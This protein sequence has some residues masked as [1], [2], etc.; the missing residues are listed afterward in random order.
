[1]QAQDKVRRDRQ[2]KEV[3]IHGFFTLEDGTKSNQ[4]V[5]PEPRAKLEI[6]TTQ[7]NPISSTATVQTTIGAKP[8][9]PQNSFNHF[10]YTEYK[11]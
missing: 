10:R 11:K 2:L 7:T 3:E 6:C 5:R 9:R 8:K 4:Q 1:M